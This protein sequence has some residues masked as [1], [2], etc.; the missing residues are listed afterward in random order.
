ML[1]LTMRGHRQLKKHRKLFL[2]SRPA[3]AF[4]KI[5]TA[6]DFD[7]QWGRQYRVTTKKI[8][9]YL[10]RLSQETGHINIVPGFLVITTGLVVSDIH[11]M[12][13]DLITQDAL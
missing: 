6:C 9:L 7:G 4:C 11:D 10:H 1:R 5:Q 2:D 8:D 12:V 3:P 13:I